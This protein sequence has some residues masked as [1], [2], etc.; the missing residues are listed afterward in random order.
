VLGFAAK[1]TVE[2]FAVLALAAGVIAH[3]VV[4]S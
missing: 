4:P 1:G 3:T 2:E